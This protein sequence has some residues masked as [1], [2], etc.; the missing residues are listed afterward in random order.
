MNGRGGIKYEEKVDGVGQAWLS[1][2]GLENGL[3]DGLGDGLEGHS[4][5]PALPTISSGFPIPHLTGGGGVR[6]I[7]RNRGVFQGYFL[8]AYVYA[9]GS[10]KHFAA[11]L[12]WKL[13]LRALPRTPHGWPSQARRQ[14]IPRPRSFQHNGGAPSAGAHTRL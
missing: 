4:M 3:G 7:T 8:C 5:I 10:I 9:N 2:R 1:D 6:P 11:R 12:G 14:A 13:H